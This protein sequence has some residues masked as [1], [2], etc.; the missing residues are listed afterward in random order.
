[1]VSNANKNPT[2]STHIPRAGATL[3]GPPQP[4]CNRERGGAK[5]RPVIPPD[6]PLPRTGSTR[7]QAKGPAKHAEP[8]AGQ[9]TTGMLSNT[10]IQ[11]IRAL[12]LGEQLQPA[13]RTETE[14]Q[15]AHAARV[16]KIF[17][18]LRSALVQHVGHAPGP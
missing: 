11:Q 5:P 10:A 14:A 18:A 12:A 17:S 15:A 3:T 13:I 9:M 7:G 1:M 6:P 4:A 8:T 16:H 2:T